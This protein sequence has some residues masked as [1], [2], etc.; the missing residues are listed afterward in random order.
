MEYNLCIN[1]IT[2]CITT[3]EEFQFDNLIKRFG[4]KEP[5]YFSEILNQLEVRQIPYLAK[6]LDKYGDLYLKAIE[7]FEKLQIL[8]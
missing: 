4:S 5:F 2:F 8:L 7:K 3:Y 6:E 1:N